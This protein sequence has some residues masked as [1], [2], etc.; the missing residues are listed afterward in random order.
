MDLNH[1]AW[2]KLLRS[3]SL[4][5]TFGKMTGDQVSTAPRGYDKD[6]PAIDLLRYKQYILKVE[7]TDADVLSPGFLAKVNDAF[8]KMRPFLD[9]VSEVLTTDANGVPLI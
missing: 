6:H 1:D 9:Y 2:R 7:F 5:A 4:V 8:K 3:K